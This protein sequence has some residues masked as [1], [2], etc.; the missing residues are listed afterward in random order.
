MIFGLWTVTP[1]TSIFSSLTFI[2]ILYFKKYIYIIFWMDYVIWKLFFKFIISFQIIYCGS[3]FSDAWLVFRFSEVFS[4][5]RL[6]SGLCNP[7]VFFKCVS[8]LHNSKATLKFRLLDYIIRNTILDY[9]IH[10]IE[11]A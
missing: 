9:I 4:N 1:C 2:Q 3:F 8:G 6:T 10:N 7:K 11:V 5:M